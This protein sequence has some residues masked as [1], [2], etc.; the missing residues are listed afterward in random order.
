M[1]TSRPADSPL[2][3]RRDLRAEVS[4]GDGVFLF[5]ERTTTVLSGRHVVALAALLDGSRDR[6]DVLDALPGGTDRAGVAAT[7]DRLVEARLVTRR[8]AGPPTAHEREHAF[9]EAAGLD[10]D[11]AAHSVRTG[12]DLL[13]PDH[14]SSL[15]DP[16]TKAVRSALTGAGM[17]VRAS[18]GGR[19]RPGGSL[20]I[21]LCADYLDP[22]LAAVDAAHRAAGRPWLLA[23]P[24][25]DQ[26]WV[27]P[28]FRPGESAC[29]HCLAER[30]WRHREAEACAQA[31]L[32]RSGPAP[33]PVVT[34]PALTGTAGSLIALEAEKWLA[35][36]R[37]SGQD[38]VQTLDGV[39]LERARHELRRRPQCPAC[40]DADLVAARAYEPVALRPVARTAYRGGGHRAAPPEEVWTRYQ[41]LVSPVTGIIKEILPDSEAPAG[42]HCFRSGPNVAAGA[43][44]LMN[45]RRG[46][47][48]D[49]GGKGVTAEEARTGALCEAVERWSGTFQGGEARRRASLRDLGDEAVHPNDVMLYDERQYAGRAD[50]NPRHGLFQHVC[51][52]FDDDVELDWTPVWSLTGERHRLLPTGMLYFGGPGPASVR[53]DSN[54][55][56]AGSCLEDAVLQGLLELVERDS[57]ALWWYNR[58]PLPGVDLDAFAQP[59]LDEA[60]DSY[61]A[62]GRTLEVLDLTTDLGVPAM[63]AVTRRPGSD[64]AEAMLGFGAHLDP[65]I[66][67][68]RA[69]TELNQ[70]LPAV[71]GARPDTGFAPGDPDAVRWWQDPAAADEPYLHADRSGSPRRPADYGYRPGPD[72]TEDL[73]GLIG[74]LDARGL[75]VLVLDQTRPDVGLP[76]VKVLVPGLRPMWARFAPGRLFD[77]PVRLGRL[78]APTPYD[79]LNPIPVFL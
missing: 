44:G 74:L 34:T 62:L 49:S 56:A 28:I 36:H 16:V 29:W 59:W 17:M 68:R 55:N 9:W 20:S 12:V 43:G 63:A 3:F 45:L 42:F 23:K 14:P 57:V 70:L 53:A 10:A 66:A 40:G 65:R 35:G 52:P 19:P 60:R 37:Y 31:A 41:H 46:P 77:A 6:D 72:L 79:Q 39:E 18:R 2:G 27:G 24:I 25:G 38:A 33:R 1:T 8:P 30:L 71:L 15:T 61:A 54:G 21:V 51:E 22:E 64:R 13:L 73:R 69:V 47:R 4:D 50:W 78:A 11:V 76:V 58:T 5:S 67:V 26:V 32:G 75:E 7:L 48:E